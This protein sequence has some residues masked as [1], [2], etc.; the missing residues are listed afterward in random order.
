M[1]Y[2][3]SKDDQFFIALDGGQTGLNQAA[4][5]KL[6]GVHQ[7]TVG[8]LVSDCRQTLSDYEP[9]QCFYKKHECDYLMESL[10]HQNLFN[11][12][13]AFGII[14]YYAEKEKNAEAISSLVAVGHIG[15]RA[16]IQ[17]VTGF[18]I[19]LGGQNDL[20]SLHDRLD[21]AKEML[22]RTD[23]KL[24]NLEYFKEN[25]S[26]IW[27]H[28]LEFRDGKSYYQDL[29]VLPP[30]VQRNAFKHINNLKEIFW[31]IYKIRRDCGVSSLDQLSKDRIEIVNQTLPA[32]LTTTRGVPGRGCD[33]K[34]WQWDKLF[35]LD[36]NMLYEETLISSD[37]QGVSK[38]GKRKDISKIKC[39]TARENRLVS[40]EPA[41]AKMVDRF[42]ADYPEKLDLFEI[43]TYRSQNNLDEAYLLERLAQ[44]DTEK[45]KLLERDFPRFNASF[46]L[47]RTLLQ[48]IA[49]FKLI[50]SMD[51]QLVVIL[52]AFRCWAQTLVDVAPPKSLLY[53]P[54]RSLPPD[55]D[56][57]IHEQY[58]GLAY[59]ERHHFYYPQ[60]YDAIKEGEAVLATMA[61]KYNIPYNNRFLM[62][63][64]YEKCQL[65]G[66]HQDFR[67]FNKDAGDMNDCKPLI[68]KWFPDAHESK[69][70][71]ES[72]YVSILK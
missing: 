71:Y 33:L 53:A 65:K 36:F 56:L 58:R 50:D 24:A 4:I 54:A 68:A 34:T 39:A 48:S 70:C 46:D 49:W 20:D 2:Q 9:L 17:H 21:I 52:N 1:S 27:Q 23:H 61:K 6:S 28:L 38:F 5:A 19:H 31:T 43:N 3:F 47:R 44:S 63:K 29:A 45:G 7:T 14:A 42:K 35:S 15:L 22:R 26:D 72:D 67:P 40:D 18:Q 8:R 37:K 32:A 66:S 12:N 60:V 59:L 11:S 57:F 64:L 51:R 25:I 30:Q 13:Y 41:I 16:Y 10:G 62:L 55:Q 69:E